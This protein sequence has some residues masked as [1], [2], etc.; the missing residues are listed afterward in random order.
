MA[1]FFDKIVY[2]CELAL[3]RS[4]FLVS[5]SKASFSVLSDLSSL[6]WK[7]ALSW[8]RRRN[9]STSCLVVNSLLFLDMGTKLR[10]LLRTDFS[11]F[12]SGRFSGIV[13]TVWWFWFTRG[14]VLFF[15]GF[16]RFSNLCFL[17]CSKWWKS[18]EFMNRGIKASLPG[19]STFFRWVYYLL[20][21]IQRHQISEGISHFLAL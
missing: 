4:P 10:P 6:L 21:E 12:E 13:T 3:W 5:V 15:R 9:F 16:V 14:A 19:F 8:T 18:L 17:V 1:A 2:W 11:A 7:N 20:T